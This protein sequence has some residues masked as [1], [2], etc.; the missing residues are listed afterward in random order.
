MTDGVYIL[1][2][3]NNVLLTQRDVLY[4]ETNFVYDVVN[5]TQR[6]H[7]QITGKIRR[8]HLLCHGIL[9]PFLYRI[10]KQSPRMSHNTCTL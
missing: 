5:Y 3:F 6:L 1:I 4:Q 10:C 9:R 7:I 8:G 2:H